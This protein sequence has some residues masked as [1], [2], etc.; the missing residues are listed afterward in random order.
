MNFASTSRSA[1]SDGIRGCSDIQPVVF[2]SSRISTYYYI[3]KVTGL[4]IIVVNSL[5]NGARS[6]KLF[7]LLTSISTESRFVA[8]H[9]HTGWSR[10][11]T[12]DDRCSGSPW[13]TGSWN[14]GTGSS[15]MSKV[16]SRT[17]AICLTMRENVCARREAEVPTLRP[18]LQ[19]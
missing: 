17:A 19:A 14:E 5:L 4:Y 13:D 18:A 8:S 12:W 16:V 11:H 1:K 15:R 3:S 10:S 7:P 6:D 9:A 2:F